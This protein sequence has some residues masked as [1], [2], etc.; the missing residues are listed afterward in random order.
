MCLFTRAYHGHTGNLIDISPYK[1]NAPGGEGKKKH[2]HVIPCPDPYRGVYKGYGPETG[3]LYANEVKALIKEAEKN[4][5]K[6]MLTFLTWRL[7]RIC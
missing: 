4:G 3:E 2:I 6:V 5:R 7:K 1:Y